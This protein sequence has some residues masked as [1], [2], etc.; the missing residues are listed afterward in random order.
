M[1]REGK[2]TT[3]IGNGVALPHQGSP[4]AVRDYLDEMLVA[5]GIHSDGVDFAAVDGAP[6]P[7]L[8]LVGAPDGPEYLQLARRVAALARDKRWTKHLRQCR[9]PRELRETIEE[10]WAELAP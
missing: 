10:A 9:T 2:G 8:F 7:I 5:V 6:V 1:G 4:E 3:G